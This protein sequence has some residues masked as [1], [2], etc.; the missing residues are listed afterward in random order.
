MPVIRLHPREV[1][2][3]LTQRPIGSP[4]HAIVWGLSMA[5]DGDF[6]LALDKRNHH[7]WLHRY[8]TPGIAVLRAQINSAHSESR[9]R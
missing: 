3:E 8:Q 4:D 1:L 5:S 7:L 2:P 6:F 9:G